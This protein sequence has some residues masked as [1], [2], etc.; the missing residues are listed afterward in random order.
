VALNSRIYQLLLEGAEY[1]AAARLP[2]TTING[3]SFHT[4]WIAAEYARDLVSER[5]PECFAR[6]EDV[7]RAL[8]DFQDL[9]PNS[10]TFGNFRWEFEDAGVEDLNAVVFFAIRIAPMP[11][12]NQSRLSADLVTELLPGVRCAIGAIDSIDVGPEYT[13]I[14]SQSVASLLIGGQVLGVNAIVALGERRFREWASL[15]DESGLAHEFN[16]PVYTQMTVTALRLIEAHCEIDGLRSLAAQVRLRQVLS[17]ALHINASTGRMSAPHCRAYFPFL[18]AETRP[19]IEIFQECV[20]AGWAPEWMIAF[21]RA[22]KGEVRETSD[23]V[24]GVHIVSHHG[25]GFSVGT[26]SRELDTQNNRYIAAQSTAFAAQFTAAGKTPG[27]LFSKYIVNDEWLGDYS[28]AVSRPKRQVFFDH[29]CF[30]GVQDGLRMIGAYRPRSLDAWHSTFSAK[31]CVILANQRQV[32]GIY[33]GGEQIENFPAEVPENMAITLSAGS[34]HV[35]IQPLSSKEL[36]PGLTNRL[37]ERDGMFVFEIRD[38][39][40]PARTFWTQAEPGSFFQGSV[41][42][43]FYAEIF[44]ASDVDDPAALAKLMDT[45]IFV[46]RAAHPGRPD[47][48]Q[49]VWTMSY[50]RDDGDFGMEIDLHKWQRVRDWTSQGAIRLPMLESSFARQSRDGCVDLGGATLTCGARAAWVAGVPD[51]RI[52]AA[53]VHP[54]DEAGP[55]RFLTPEGSVD[56][57]ATQSATILWRNGQVKVDYVDQDAEISVTGGV[58]I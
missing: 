17:V 11:Y 53:S 13:N 47:R 33:V 57:S 48:G 55:I 41:R 37:L 14:I 39:D 29:G 50:Q 4:M 15:I 3:N 23:R 38:Y 32:D 18:V 22:D 36:Q 25:E 7:L 35:V 9:D 28:T 40:G 56:I 21:T 6:G 58:L 19:E 49:R 52:W 31:T 2:R 43:G 30:L 16:S 45:G 34:I 5:S 51:Q 1:D 24:R 44:P 54:G 20:A 42:A 12:Q 46:N 26:A 10:P 27:T 8:T